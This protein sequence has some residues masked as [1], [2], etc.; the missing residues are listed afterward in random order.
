MEAITEGLNIL[1]V[2]MAGVFLFLGIMVIGMKVLELLIHWLEIHFPQ[3]V[4]P[5][6]GTGTKSSEDG[7]QKLAAALVAAYHNHI[8]AKGRN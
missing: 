1:V 7:N 4:P 2:G 3:A 6:P 8:T 5:S